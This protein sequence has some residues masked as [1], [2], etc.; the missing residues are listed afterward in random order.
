MA[1][2]PGLHPVVRAVR[3]AVAEALLHLLA[4]LETHPAPAQAKE[5]MAAQVVEI[6]LAL[7]VAARALLEQTPVQMLQA[8]A[9]LEPHPQYLAHL[10]LTQVAAEAVRLL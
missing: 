7:A 4:A 3:A 1:L 10:L 6:L 9:V 8:L 2:H 5:I